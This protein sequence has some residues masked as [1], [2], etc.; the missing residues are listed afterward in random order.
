MLISKQWHQPR[1]ATA[2]A[3]SSRGY[4]YLYAMSSNLCVCDSVGGMYDVMTRGA[5]P[6]LTDYQAEASEGAGL[7]RKREK[8]VS[9][10]G[11]GRRAHA[12]F[13]MH[14]RSQSTTREPAQRERGKTKNMKRCAAHMEPRRQL[15]VSPAWLRRPLS[16]HRLPAPNMQAR[17]VRTCQGDV[18][19]S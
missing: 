18:P 19:V 16:R 3:S 2:W 8:R 12:R 7:V 1:C 9:T 11:G 17:K 15:A 10:R 5:T 14:V 4:T 13:F 6:R